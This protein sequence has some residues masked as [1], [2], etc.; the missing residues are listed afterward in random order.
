MQDEKEKAPR[1]VPGGLKEE[2]R[3]NKKEKHSL[4]KYL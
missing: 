4:C 1:F 3:T 2:Q